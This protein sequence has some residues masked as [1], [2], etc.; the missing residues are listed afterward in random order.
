M[1]PVMR[2]LIATLLLPGLVGAG[3]GCQHIGGKCDCQ[4]HPSDTV[5]QG[6]TAPYPTIPVAALPPVTTIP[7][8]DPNGKGKPETKKNEEMD[9]NSPAFR[10]SG[11]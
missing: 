9:E 11:N 2:R 8:S 5:I 3:L 1:G 4:A 6:P 7:P 10:P